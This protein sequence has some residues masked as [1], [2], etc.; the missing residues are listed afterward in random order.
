M[1]RKHSQVPAAV[2]ELARTVRF[3][4]VPVAWDLEATEN[5]PPDVGAAVESA[6]APWETGSVSRATIWGEGVAV[7]GYVLTVDGDPHRWHRP[8]GA[9]A[10]RL[11]GD[12]ATG[13]G[14]L[15]LPG[16]PLEEARALLWALAEEAAEA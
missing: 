14:W 8:V 4:Q 9:P 3:H 1:A 16:V 11:T 12:M 10:W 13:Q 15:P 6:L 2:R 5:P 7:R